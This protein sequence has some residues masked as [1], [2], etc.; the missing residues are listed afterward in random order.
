MQRNIKLTI[1]YD[2]TN[3]LGWQI[4]KKGRTIQGELQK[5]LE[6]LLKEKINLI[7]AGRTDAGVHA[8]GQVANF[9]SDN[10]LGV[11]QLLKALNNLLPKDIV[12]KNTQE[13]ALDFNARFK[14]KSRV[15]RYKI[16]LGKTAILRKLVWEVF[17][18]LDIKKMKQGLKIIKGY[19]KFSHFGKKNE[20]RHDYRCEIL[21]TKCEVKRNE[22]SFEIEANRFLRGMVR[23]IV[24]TLVEIGRG[25]LG[26]NEFA[27]MLNNQSRKAVKKAPAGGLYL[28]KVKY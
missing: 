27:K 24:G 20:D 3:F 7:G 15:Y 10:K 4:Q 23:N 21:K 9:K 28:V 8:L 25:N 12:I 14:A 22:V 26:I 2:G 18:P 13:M 17:Q 19:H 11:G 1:E 5:A 16:F 6:K